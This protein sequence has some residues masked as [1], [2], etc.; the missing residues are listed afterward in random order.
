MDALQGMDVQLMLPLKVA[1][2]QLKDAVRKVGT[3]PEQVR[4]YLR[5]K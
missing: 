3:S 1:P 4:H 5:G 2:D